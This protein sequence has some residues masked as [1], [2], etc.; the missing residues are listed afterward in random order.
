MSDQSEKITRLRT[1]LSEAT[2]DKPKRAP[3]RKPATP[4]GNVIYVNGR[5]VAVHHEQEMI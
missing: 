5:G 4:A 1:A 3:R 2:P